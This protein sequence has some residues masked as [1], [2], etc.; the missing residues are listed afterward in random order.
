MFCI[1][2]SWCILRNKPILHNSIYVFK[3]LY[4]CDPVSTPM[5]Q[6]CSGNKCNSLVIFFLTEEYIIIN[7]YSNTTLFISYKLPKPVYHF[8]TEPIYI[9][10]LT[11]FL[12]LFF[13]FQKQ[14]TFNFR[15]YLLFF[16][17]ESSLQKKIGYQ[18]D[19]NRL[20]SLF[21]SQILIGSQQIIDI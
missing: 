8:F 5:T 1:R 20:I 7:I 16:W 4:F 18:Y 13:F 3:A 2:R 21:I 9:S 19:L 6:R 14:S 12:E 11:Q 15:L 10:V 17:D